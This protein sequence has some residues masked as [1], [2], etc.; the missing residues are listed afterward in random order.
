[1]FSQRLAMRAARNNSTIYSSTTKAAPMMPNSS[2]MMT[3]IKSLNACG[4][5]SRSTDCPGP[6][7]M[8]LLLTMAM[9]A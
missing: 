6:F 4:R 2:M 8:I 5:K 9:F 7:Q 1:L 3:K